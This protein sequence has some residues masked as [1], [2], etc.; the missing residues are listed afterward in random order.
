MNTQKIKKVSV[1]VLI[2]V[3][4]S[5]FILIP[6]NSFFGEGSIDSDIKQK[7]QN[8][9]Y[10]Y[11][12]ELVDTLFKKYVAL[13]RY[14]NNDTTLFFPIY[15]DMSGRVEGLSID[16]LSFFIYAFLV[17]GN[18]TYLTY[19]FRVA[20]DIAS[21]IND[22][23]ILRVVDINGRPRED[24][25]VMTNY[26][27]PILFAW[28]SNYSPYYLHIAEV[29]TN[30]VIKYFISPFGLPYGSVYPSGKPDYSAVV[31]IPFRTVGVIATL[32]KMYEFTK[33]ETYLHYALNV[34]FA[35][36]KYLQDKK[37]GLLY[38]G[39]R[40]YVSNSSENIKIRFETHDVFQRV[41]SAGLLIANMIYLY[42]LSKNE[43]LLNLLKRYVNSVYKYFWV[44]DSNG[45][46]H[47][48][49]RVYTSG[50][51][52][53]D[54]IETNVFK[55][56]YALLLYHLFI[57]RNESIVSRIITDI[58][59]TI[60]YDSVNYIFK[61]APS[62]EEALIYG[63]FGSFSYLITLLKQLG[64]YDFSSWFI[65]HVYAVFNAF[66]KKYGIVS[67][68]LPEKYNETSSYS[69]KVTPLSTAYI[70]SV[71]YFITQG[72]IWS[73]VMFVPAPLTYL[74]NVDIPLIPYGSN[75]LFFPPTYEATIC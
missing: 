54:T 3:I 71:L 62:R 55:L 46:L 31:R 6:S 67:S 66:M 74:P 24:A 53:W 9:L 49:Y 2:L 50:K 32:S 1:V 43:L 69:P 56:D 59:T 13:K 30:A 44:N 8:V 57:E 75:F 20:N 26:F 21:L 39:Y 42:R 47:W 37:T 61:H 73:K 35:I 5:A 60:M 58:N 11:I 10:Q 23:G 16:S 36:F 41:Y 22:N 34:T 33:N 48:A 68:I 4:I 65:K 70:Y 18:Y 7:R 52:Y 14:M 63:Q 64:Y 40:F 38:D 27:F 72:G 51:I 45:H 28:L 12:K 29:L 17:T 19:A 25:P 15:N